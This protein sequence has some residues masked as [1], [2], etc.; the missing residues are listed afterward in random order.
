MKTLEQQAPDANAGMFSAD[1][2]QLSKRKSIALSR[3]MLQHYLFLEG[4]PRLGSV[5]WILDDDLVLE[6]LGYGPNGCVQNQDVDY[7]SAIHQLKETGAGVVLCEVTCD[8]PLPVLSCIR[9][10]LVDLYHNLHWLASMEPDAPFHGLQDENRLAR[11]NRRD[12]Y[13]DLSTAGTDHLELP[14]WYEPSDHRLCVGQVFE[15]M[16]SRLP[17]VLSGK[18]VF[19]PLT[20]VESGDSVSATFPSVNR[21]PATLVFDLQALREFPNAVPAIDGADTRRS[22]MVWSLL[23]RFVGGREI[24]QAHLPVRQVREAVSSLYPDFT[25]LA[26]DIRGYGLY[27]SLQEVFRHKAQQRQNQGKEPSG[28]ALLEFDD[29]EIEWAIGLYQTYVRE[30]VNA[31]ELSFLRIMGVISALRPFCQHDPAGS[32]A[33]W[34]LGRPEH[35]GLADGLRSFVESLRSIYTDAR[36]DDFSQHVAEVDV[37]TIEGFFKS[38]PDIVNS[39]RANTPLPVDELRE[40]AVAYVRSEFQTG[41]LACLG[42]GEEGVVLTDRQLVYKYFHRWNPRN[43]DYPSAF[44]H[45]LIGKLSGYKSLLDLREI[46]RDGDHVV[47]LYPY[48]AG[49]K[50]EGGHLEGLLTLLRECRQAGIACR[51]IHPDNLLVT[52]TGLKLIDYGADIVAASDG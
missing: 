30:R 29:G 17:G 50:Y 31:F 27:S 47:A 28:Q 22:D 52:A 21:G 12:Y 20:R 23:N 51:N 1:M 15:E 45:S 33:P 18:Q 37:G 49:A 24:I 38:L 48:E 46:R 19:R 4:K 43:R 44:L 3:T 39:P 7:V 6:G 11:M 5:V 26:Q 40:A 8:P 9:T 35:R 13:Y 42:I 41:P 25:T 10:Q 2:E 16:V 36:M 14:F 34:W 32:S